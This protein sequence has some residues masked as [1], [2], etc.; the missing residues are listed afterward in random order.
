MVS[1]YVTYQNEI[2]NWSDWTNR[3]VVSAYLFP[4]VDI[5][6][7]AS[8]GNFGAYSL[9]SDYGWIALAADA[10]YDNPPQHGHGEEAIYQIYQYQ[11]A[12]IDMDEFE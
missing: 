7:E 1:G 12:N 5:I 10:D 2:Y 4:P 11:Y 3:E 9:E 8:F 6:D